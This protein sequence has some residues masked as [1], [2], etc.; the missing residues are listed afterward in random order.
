VETFKSGKPVALITGGGTGIGAATARKLSKT[1]HVVICGRRLDRLE[2]IA[3]E[4]NGLAIQ[5][6]V[7]VE[8]D[9]DHLFHQIEEE[10]GRLDALVLNAG[11]NYEG[12]VTETSLEDWENVIHINL[13]SG[14]IV[15]KAAIPYL[16]KNGGSIVTIS[17]V[18]GLR[19]APSVPAYCASK[20]G[21][22]A[23]TQSIAVDYAKQNIR[24]NV[25][26]P[27]WVKT[28]MADEEMNSLTKNTGETVEE[29]YRR[30]TKL[31]PARRPSNPEE[32]AN[33]VG[34]LISPEASFVTGSVFPVD[35]GSLT[36]DVGMVEFME[37]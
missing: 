16:E 13:T 9:V 37:T 28:E 1:H 5:A 26:C 22:I 7:G 18:A 11:I 35:G 19:T 25:V 30:V 6:D 23:L 29:A 14:F 2:E 8:R 12:K 10:Y 17:S 31:I 32:I 24:A 33:A 36:V 20:A 21:I 34:W 15:A 27:G 4:I 3:N